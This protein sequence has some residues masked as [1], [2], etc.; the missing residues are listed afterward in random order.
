M[1]W[2]TDP[3]DYGDHPNKE[4]SWRFCR[5]FL[6]PEQKLCTSTVKLDDELVLGFH[7]GSFVFWRRKKECA[8]F[9]TRGVKSSNCKFWV[10]S[11]TSAFAFWQNPPR[12]QRR[13]LAIVD[14]V[15]GVRWVK[16]EW[17]IRCMT[18]HNMFWVITKK[19]LYQID[20][21]GAPKRVIAKAFSNLTYVYSCFVDVTR[22]GLS[23][24]QEATGD[25][26]RVVEIKEKVVLVETFNRREV[27][28][29]V[30]DKGER[31]KIVLD[32]VSGL[33]RGLAGRPVC[34]CILS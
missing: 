20:Q 11:P 5:C 16:N 19:A 33:T 32:V 18:G 22:E 17:A 25:T 12:G 34:A 27:I 13:N 23:I 26:T 14:L 8:R 4:H 9:A 15:S 30:T 3:D 10:R 24:I 6:S 7:R 31:S 28:V 1:S 21:H 2:S 29:T